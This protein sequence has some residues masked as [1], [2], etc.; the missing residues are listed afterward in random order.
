M[1]YADNL[2]LKGERAEDLKKRLLKR[3]DSFCSKEIKVNFGKKKVM[4]YDSIG[5][6]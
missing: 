4:V 2:T 6:M 1:M 5:E 3:K